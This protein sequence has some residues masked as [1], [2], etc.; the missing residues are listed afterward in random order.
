[1][2]GVDERGHAA[3]LLSIGDGVQGHRGL[4]AGFRTIDFDNSPAR[5]SLSAESQIETHRS[6]RNPLNL[7]EAPLVQGHNRALAEFL[8]DLRQG[9]FQFFIGHFGHGL[10]PK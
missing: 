9:V 10:A 6:G 4:A 2:L 3:P 7:L 1:V 8:L 5:N